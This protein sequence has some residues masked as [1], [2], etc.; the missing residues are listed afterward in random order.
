[1]SC[2]CQRLRPPRAQT[3][4]LSL[5]RPTSFCPDIPNGHPKGFLANGK[6]TLPSNNVGHLQN[7][8]HHIPGHSPMIPNGSALKS[9]RERLSQSAFHINKLDAL[10]G[11]YMAA[12]KQATSSSTADLC[13][14]RGKLYETSY[15][16]T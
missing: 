11:Q 2:P 15:I 14:H 5:P 4:I 12:E 13:S 1:M 9:Q 8:N 7:T 16:F 3:G 6:I 10:T